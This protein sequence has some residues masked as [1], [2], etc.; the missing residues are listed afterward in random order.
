MSEKMRSGVLI[1]F[2]V[3]G[4]FSATLLGHV[5]KP[6]MSRQFPSSSKLNL[7][8]YVD[9]SMNVSKYKREGHRHIGKQF[10]QPF[11]L[12]QRN[13]SIFLN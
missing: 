9:D 6:T 12:I 10:S 5:F 4:K 13:I 7:R 1:L 11:I 2:L 8:G 3:L